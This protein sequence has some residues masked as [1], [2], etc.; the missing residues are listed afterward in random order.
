MNSGRTPLET[1]DSILGSLGSESR[2]NLGLERIQAA[3]QEVTNP[4]NRVKSVVIAGTNG[5]GTTS[6]LISNAL[7]R[8]GLRVGTYLSPHLQSITERFLCDL[9]PIENAQLEALALKHAAIA[10]THGLSYFEFLTLLYFVWA[11]QERFDISVLEV[12]LGGRLDATN[13]THPAATVVTRIDF[14]HQRYLGETLEKILTEKLGILRAQTPLYS[15][16]RNHALKQQCLKT[17]QKLGCAVFFSDTLP[18]RREA[19][20]WDGQQI[21]ISGIPFRL[22]NASEGTVENAALAYALLR[23]EFAVPIEVIQASFAQTAIP[24]RFEVVSRNPQ[25][26]LSGDHNL[27]GLD[28]LLRTLNALKATRLHTLCAFSLDK[29][30]TQMYRELASRSTSITLTA[31]KKTASHLPQ[32]YLRLGRVEPDPVQ[33]F[34]RIAHRIKALDTILVTGSLYLVAEIRKHLKNDVSFITEAY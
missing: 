30:Y 33:A 17:A 31:F 4:H 32:H 9:R 25:V 8:H 3:L 5:K 1:L 28:C 2:I 24:G 23:Q 15:S 18:V 13:V 29:P 6:L 14:D 20:A 27:S 16:I 11:D 21:A 10:R 7:R 22:Q 19:L 26:V 12:G 34:T